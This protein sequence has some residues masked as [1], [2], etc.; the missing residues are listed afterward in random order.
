MS[1]RTCR[2]AAAAMAGWLALGLGG[3][4]GGSSASNEALD[5]LLAGAPA[6]YEYVIPEGTAAAAATSNTHDPIFP[7]F[8]TAWVGESIRIVNDDV[9]AHTV[10]PFAIGSGQTLTQLFTTEGVYTGICSTHD[11]ATFTLTINAT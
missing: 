8:L 7:D 11:G 6:T 4:G 2:V 1:R 9:A 5:E 10:G 3:C